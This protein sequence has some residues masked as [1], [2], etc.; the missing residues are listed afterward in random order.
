VRV[1]LLQLKY[2]AKTFRRATTPRFFVNSLPKSGTNLVVSLTDAYGL[3]R[4]SGPIISTRAHPD[5]FRNR[6]GMI[7]GHVE[8][9]DDLARDTG[10]DKGFL[11]IRRPADYAVSLARYI[12][13]S[14]RHPLHAALHDL[15][16]EELLTAVIGGTRTAESFSLDPVATRYATY[17]ESAKAAG[18]VL[19]DFDELRAG[20]PAGG[21]ETAFLELIGGPDYARNFSAMLTRSQETSST[22]RHSLRARAVEFPIAK[23]TGHASLVAAERMYDEALRTRA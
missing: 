2:F 19:L 23:M 6:Q 15:P 5:L 13:A 8:H 4:I 17:L 20:G 22:F 3:L 16:P 10:V 7:F 18:L 21:A 11:L 14:R 12:V 1:K 9:M